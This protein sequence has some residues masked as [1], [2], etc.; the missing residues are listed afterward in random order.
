MKL[1][2]ALADRAG[3]ARRRE[4]LRARIIGNARYHEG[5]PHA[6]D[7]GELLVEASAVMD[8]LETLI[9]RINRTNATA[10]TG[11]DGMRAWPQSPIRRAR[12]SAA[13]RSAGCGRS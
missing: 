3:A 6:E 13:S 7:A 9:R 10:T 8:E 5:E 11:D 12:I 1:A 4:Q 2:E